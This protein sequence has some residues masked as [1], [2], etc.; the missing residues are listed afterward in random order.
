V[1]EGQPTETFME[2]KERILRS[3]LTEGEG[4]STESLDVFSQEAQ[5][6]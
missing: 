4:N 6:E 3:V 2:E 5:Q 1:I